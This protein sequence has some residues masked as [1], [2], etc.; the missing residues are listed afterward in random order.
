MPT[1]A[2]SHSARA[3]GLKIKKKS[4][5]LTYPTYYLKKYNVSWTPLETRN[6]SARAH[7]FKQK[8]S[9]PLT[10]PTYYLKK[11]SMYHGPL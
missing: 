8:Q 2:R 1:E 5:P 7:G 9:N 10:Y 6:H 3:H 4:N 11:N